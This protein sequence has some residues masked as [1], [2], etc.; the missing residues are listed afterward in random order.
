M[1]STA[2]SL[3]AIGSISA[4]SMRSF[5][6]TSIPPKPGGFSVTQFKQ[7]SGFRAKHAPKMVRRVARHRSA[8]LLKMFDEESSAQ[9][10]P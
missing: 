2:D 4:N 7:L 1:V 10:T 6:T 8:V 5:R 3:L 9:A